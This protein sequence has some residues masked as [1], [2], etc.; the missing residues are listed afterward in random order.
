MSSR[1]VGARRKHR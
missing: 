1:E